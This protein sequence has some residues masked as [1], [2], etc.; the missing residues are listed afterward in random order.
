VGIHPPTALCLPV[1]LYSIAPLH[2]SITHS[3]QST[4][5]YTL[6]RWISIRNV[7]SQQ[8]CHSTYVVL[9]P[10]TYRCECT[11]THTHTHMHAR[12][13]AHT[14]ARANERTRSTAIFIRTNQPILF[15]STWMISFPGGTQFPS[16]WNREFTGEPRANTSGPAPRL[17]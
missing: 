16:W 12:T 7:I 10:L 1:S 14:H 5:P 8:R 3:H 13:H 4:S 2:L 9:V 6:Y 15:L 17:H 11:Y